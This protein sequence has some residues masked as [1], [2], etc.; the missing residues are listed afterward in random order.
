MN[1]AILLSKAREKFRVVP[2][3]PVVEQE[4]ALETEE[5]TMIAVMR[6]KTG[7]RTNRMEMNTYL[8]K[9]LREKKTMQ[10]SWD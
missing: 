1:Q 10:R 6:R 2:N 3:G 7:M 8:L 5:M 9:L 4:E